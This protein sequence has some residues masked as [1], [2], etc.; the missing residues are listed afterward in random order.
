LST[1]LDHSKKMLPGSA[2]VALANSSV[3][4]SHSSIRSGRIVNLMTM[5][6]IDFP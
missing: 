6:I 4:D 2:R 1:L 3:R 5:K